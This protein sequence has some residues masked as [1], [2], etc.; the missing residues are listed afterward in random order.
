MCSDLFKRAPERTLA[1]ADAWYPNW[2]KY[3]D[4]IAKVPVASAWEFDKKAETE[5]RAERDKILPQ[6]KDKPTPP[7]D[8][9][10][11]AST[12]GFGHGIYSKYSFFVA[13]MDRCIKLRLPTEI[14]PAGQPLKLRDVER[15][16]GWVGD[17]NEIGEYCAIA[18]YSEAK[19]MGAPMWMPDAYAAWMWRSYH[20]AK[21][22]VRLT[23]PI[24]E[25]SKNN[26]KWGG[27]ECGLGYNGA[28]KAGSPLRF[29][30]DAPLEI[31]SIEFHDGDSIV[32]TASAAPWEV[33]S[34]KLAPGLHA[35]FA[36]SVSADGTRQTSHPAFVIVE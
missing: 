35:L 26:G 21:P 28:L 36:V 16:K 12:Y 3:P 13:Y 30:A 27:P 8:L 22:T 29:A 20:S 11:Y 32:G 2:P 7:G 34:V 24:I 4:L 19:G 18:P 23:A 15:E 10:C 25:Y 33:K 17:F 9:R 5:R 6:V 31:A 1:W 14:P